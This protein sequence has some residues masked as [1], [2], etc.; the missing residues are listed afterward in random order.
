MPGGVECQECAVGSYSEQGQ[1][2]C[3]ACPDDTTTI[4]KGAQSVDACGE[5]N[6]VV[7]ESGGVSLRP[8]GA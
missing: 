6:G 7:E 4:T 2:V 8:E 1:E 5:C 3:S